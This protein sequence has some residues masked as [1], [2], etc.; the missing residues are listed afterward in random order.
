MKDNASQRQTFGG[1]IIGKL[2]W[3]W[4]ISMLNH[5]YGENCCLPEEFYK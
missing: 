4:N 5:K 1:A 3:I 2:S